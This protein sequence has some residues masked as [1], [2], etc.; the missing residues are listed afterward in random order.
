MIDSLR[1][2]NFRLRRPVQEVGEL[3]LDASLADRQGAFERDVSLLKECAAVFAVPLGR[4]P[5]TLVEVGIALALAKPVIVFDPRQE[6]N[7]TMVVAGSALYSVD[8]DDCLNELYRILG[9]P[10]PHSS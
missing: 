9:Q 8:L 1:Y 4:D 5:G 7:N 6:N 2:H 3:R 10:S